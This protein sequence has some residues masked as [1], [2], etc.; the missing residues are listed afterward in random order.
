MTERP[1]RSHTHTSAVSDVTLLFTSECDGESVRRSIFTVSRS[2]EAP[3][4]FGVKAVKLGRQENVHSLLKGMKRAALIGCCCSAKTRPLITFYMRPRPLLN[5][6][7]REKRLKP[8]TL[9][10]KTLKKKKKF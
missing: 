10:P 5:N 3:P 4:V 1:T 9:Q 8:K 7:S 2:D 6:R